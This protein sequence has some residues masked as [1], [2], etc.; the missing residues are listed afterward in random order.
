[1]PARMKKTEQGKGCSGKPQGNFSVLRGDSGGLR[2]EFR[3]YCVGDF[4]RIAWEFRRIALGIP[5]DCVGVGKLYGNFGK[6]HGKSVK[7]P[8]AE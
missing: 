2:G 8:F 7:I 5:A 1:M 4:G 6:S 3:A